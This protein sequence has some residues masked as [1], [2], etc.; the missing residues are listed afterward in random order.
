MEQLDLDTLV[1]PEFAQPP[2]LWLGQHIPIDTGYRS[3]AVARELDEAHRR[4]NRSS[5]VHDASDYHYPRP[6][7]STRYT[8]G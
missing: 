7:A 5:D 8:A 2:C 1:E 3:R 4:G 6:S